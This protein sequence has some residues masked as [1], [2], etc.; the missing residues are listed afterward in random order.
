MVHIVVQEVAEQIG[1]TT[2][3][4]SFSEVMELLHAGMAMHVI[5]ARD[6]RSSR[7]Q[8]R[9]LARIYRIST[10]GLFLGLQQSSSF[11]VDCLYVVSSVEGSRS[12]PSGTSLAS[13]R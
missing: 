10:D 1:A 6:D 8:E 11:G 3:L 2:S 13:T 7:F 5:L 12:I 9:E 4:R